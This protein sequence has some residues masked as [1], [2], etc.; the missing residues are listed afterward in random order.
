LNEQKERKE[1]VVSLLEEF[2]GMAHVRRLKFDGEK[3]VVIFV[4][5]TP[6]PTMTEVMSRLRGQFPPNADFGHVR[7]D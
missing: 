6:K 1:Y 4:K 7:E 3:L 5:D 2:G